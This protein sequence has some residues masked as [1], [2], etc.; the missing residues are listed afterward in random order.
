MHTPIADFIDFNL[1]QGMESLLDLLWAAHLHSID[2]ALPKFTDKLKLLPEPEQR[3]GSAWAT[4]VDFIAATYFPCD[5]PT[6][7]VL[8][9]LLP[10]RVI[11]DEDKVP[12]ISDF[13]RLQNR[14]VLFIDGLDALNTA[15]H[16][17]AEKWW[18][19]EAM[20]TERDRA[21]GREMITLG[22]YRPIIFVEDMKLLLDE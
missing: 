21:L 18:S 15:T 6:T 16:G 4:I 17:G 12:F 20:R 1:T 19:S 13:S 22:V 9:R 11:Q 3:F 14:A 5:M 10:P 2:S 8:Q 7:D